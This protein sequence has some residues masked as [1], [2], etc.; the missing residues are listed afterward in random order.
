MKRMELARLMVGRAERWLRSSQDALKGSRYDD[1]MYCAQMCSEQAAKA[2]LV[3]LGIEYPRVHDVSDAMKA[4]EAKLPGWF[5]KKMDGVCS[6][7]TD[8]AKRRGEAGYG[9]EKGLDV[10][11]FKDYA[12][13]AVKKA[14]FVLGACK[15]FVESHKV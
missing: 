2:V 5:R 1:A 3:L 8:L 9:F 6:I 15:K 4:V 13:G 12:P 11:Y 14:K 10:S 7:L